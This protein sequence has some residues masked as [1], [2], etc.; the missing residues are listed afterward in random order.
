[1]DHLIR[2]LVDAS[3]IEAGRLSVARRPQEVEGLVDDVI[4]MMLPIATERTLRIERRL[5]GALPPVDC[6][7]ERIL[8]V[9][10]NLIGNAIR[11]T[12]SGGSITVM[13][14]PVGQT[15]RFCVADTGSG[16]PAE[17]LPHLFDR[18]WQTGRSTRSSAGLGLY[19][20]KG[21]VEAHGGGVWAE[22]APLGGATFCFTIPAVV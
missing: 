17:A 14:E 19:I 10:S 20:V 3:A 1:M 8:Q 15:V 2:N 12:P 9:F 5:A 11:F 7:R 18:Y 22:N 13:A 4:R 6:D 16:F 21:I